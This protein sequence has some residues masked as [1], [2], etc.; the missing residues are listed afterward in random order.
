MHLLNGTMSFKANRICAPKIFNACPCVS[1]LIVASTHEYKHHIRDKLSD[2]W[3][4]IEQHSNSLAGVKVSGIDNN[5]IRFDV[6]R[7]L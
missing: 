1:H 7:R 3:N 4:C 2:N 6:Q 5:V